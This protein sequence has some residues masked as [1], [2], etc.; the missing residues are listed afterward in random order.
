[1]FLWRLSVVADGLLMHFGRLVVF[2]AASKTFCPETKLV[3][4]GF[5]FSL[6]GCQPFR[7]R[8][9]TNYQLCLEKYMQ[10]LLFI[11]EKGSFPC[12]KENSRSCPTCPPLHSA[13]FGIA[14]E[15][16]QA[17]YIPMALHVFMLPSDP[18]TSA[19]NRKPVDNQSAIKCRIKISWEFGS[20]VASGC[21]RS[22]LFL[23]WLG[24]KTVP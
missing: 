4:R 18:R 6:I 13:I 23:V 1:M 7:D 15:F 9:R 2:A 20:L 19:I 10:D 12:T 5:W 22:L 8:S 14:E 3:G 21:L 11:D 24:L 17:A 16:I